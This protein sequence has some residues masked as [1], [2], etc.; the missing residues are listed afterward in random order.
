M[1][2]VLVHQHYLADVVGGLIVA[3][4]VSR[5][6]LRLAANRRQQAISP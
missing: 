3:F 4:G 6:T 2:T 1:S 5:V